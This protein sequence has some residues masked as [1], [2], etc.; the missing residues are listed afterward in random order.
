MRNRAVLRGSPASGGII[1]SAGRCREGHASAN[2][3]P[4]A[5]RRSG[6]NLP[7]PPSPK[8]AS[9]IRGDGAPKAGRPHRAAEEVARPITRTGFPG[10]SPDH[11]PGPGVSCGGSDGGFPAAYGR[12]HQAATTR[13]QVAACAVPGAGGEVRPEREARPQA[14]ATRPPRNRTRRGASSPRI[15]SGARNR[16]PAPSPD[17]SICA[18]GSAPK[19]EITQKIPFR[20]TQ[21]FL[22]HGVFRGAGSRESR[23]RLI[24]T[25]GEHKPHTTSV[26]KSHI[27]QGKCTDRSIFFCN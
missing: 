8:P 10:R 11:G 27:L 13:P 17:R 14:A 9:V 20:T 4:D 3:R 19:W 6:G 15:P 7:D 2:R 25:G 12:G 16:S 21:R 22:P 23:V 5:P 18:R 24:P 1:P 26:R